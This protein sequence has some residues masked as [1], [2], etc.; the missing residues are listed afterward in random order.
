MQ[1]FYYLEVYRLCR[2]QTFI[3]LLLFVALLLKEFL[4]ASKAGEKYES[5]NTEIFVQK[6]SDLWF[7][8]PGGLKLLFVLLPGGNP[9]LAEVVNR[10]LS[11]M[12]IRVPFLLNLGLYLACLAVRL[13]LLLCNFIF[14]KMN[15]EMKY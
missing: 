5:A 12:L 2:N 10:S 7:V 8:V 15:T 11:L 3:P 13:S 9:L 4:F 6:G 14:L 1:Y